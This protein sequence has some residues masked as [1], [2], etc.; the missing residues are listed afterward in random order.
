M[1]I[2]DRPD[3]DDIIASTW[4]RWAHDALADSAL[5]PYTPTC[6]N[7]PQTTFEGAWSRSGQLVT[8]VIV[9][10]GAGGSATGAPSFSLPIPAIKPTAGIDVLTNGTGYL[11]DGVLKLLHVWIRW[12]ANPNGFA[13]PYGGF[14]NA[15][16][17]PMIVSN[18]PTSGALPARHDFRLSF[19]YWCSPADAA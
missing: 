10:N 2:P 1:P 9:S 4:G 18:L 8:A 11:N 12:E 5:T 14:V 3:P 13:V 15:L 6:L 17:T 19:S 7:W 16:N